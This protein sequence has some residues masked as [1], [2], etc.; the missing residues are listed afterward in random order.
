MV[1]TFFYRIYCSYWFLTQHLGKI[2]KAV[3]S[4]A[5]CGSKPSKAIVGLGGLYDQARAVGLRLFRD[6]SIRIDSDRFSGLWHAFDLIG[7]GFLSRRVRRSSLAPTIVPAH[8]L[9]RGGIQPG[10]F[11][12]IRS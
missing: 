3:R 6:H 5:Y 9:F 7:L 12:H 2:K 4:L 1:I 11:R 10:R 8:S